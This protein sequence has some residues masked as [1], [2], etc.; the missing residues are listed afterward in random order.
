MPANYLIAGMAR[1]Y[2]MALPTGEPYEKRKQQ[3]S[4]GFSWKYK[5]P[6]AVFRMNKNR[7]PFRMAAHFSLTDRLHQLLRRSA[8]ARWYER[9][10]R[11]YSRPGRIDLWITPHECRS[12]RQS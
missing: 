12:D 1:S 5:R 4:R 2:K 10:R 11:I 8:A 3:S 9:T 6:T 7:Q